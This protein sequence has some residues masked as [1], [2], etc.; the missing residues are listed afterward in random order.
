MVQQSV[1]AKVAKNSVQQRTWACR[2]RTQTHT[3]QTHGADTRRRHTAQTQAL[4]SGRTK[5]FQ[6]H[7]H[8][9]LCVQ[10][11]VSYCEKTRQ[12]ATHTTFRQC[13]TYLHGD[14]GHQGLLCVQS[15]VSYCEKTRQRAT[16]T[17][18][19]Q[20]YTYLRVLQR[21]ADAPEEIR[22]LAGVA[23]EHAH[24]VRQQLHVHEKG[25]Q[26]YVRHP[27]P[28]EVQ[29]V[30]ER[31]QERPRALLVRLDQIPHAFD[32]V[33]PVLELAHD[34]I[35][36][37]GFDGAV[38]R[39]AFE[40]YVPHQVVDHHDRLVQQVRLFHGHLEQEEEEFRN[41]RARRRVLDGQKR[42]QRA[43]LRRE[44]ALRVAQPVAPVEL[45][46]VEVA[47]H[48][49]QPR[50]PDLAVH[51]HPDADAVLHD[52]VRGADDVRVPVE[53]ALRVAP[54]GQGRR[55]RL[56]RGD[57]TAGAAVVD[58]L[59]GGGGG[60]QGARPQL[61]F[62]HV[63][64]LLQLE[65]PELGCRGVRHAGGGALQL[66]A[67]QARVHLVHQVAHGPLVSVRQERAVELGLGE[68]TDF[69]FHDWVFGARTPIDAAGVQPVHQ[70]Q[71]RV[72]HLVLRG[73]EHCAR[74]GVSAR[75]QDTQHRHTQTHTDTHR[76]TQTHTDTHRHTRTGFHD[77]RAAP[78]PLAVGGVPPPRLGVRVR[79][80]GGVV[81][82][83]DAATAGRIRLHGQRRVAA[84]VPAVRLAAQPRRRV[85]ARAGVVQTQH[86][87]AL[88]ARVRPGR[89]RERRLP[90]VPVRAVVLQ[91]PA[92]RHPL[93]RR[94]ILPRPVGARP[95]DRQFKKVAVQNVR[96]R[97]PEANAGAH[98]LRGA[99]HR[100]T[101]DGGEKRR[102]DVAH[103]LGGVAQVPEHVLQLRLR[104]AHGPVAG[105][106]GPHLLVVG[107]HQKR[108]V[109][110]V[111]MA[112][113]GV[114]AQV[115]AGGRR[116][117]LPQL[118]A[119]HE[120]FGEPQGAVVPLEHLPP[121]SLAS[122]KQGHHGELHRQGRRNGQGGGGGAPQGADGAEQT[123]EKPIPVERRFETAVQARR[124]RRQPRGARKPPLQQPVH[125]QRAAVHGL[126]QPDLRHL[127]Y[128]QK[129]EH[130]R[131][132]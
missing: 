127:P 115:P 74:R 117:R 82:K 79:V 67:L 107:G 100:D 69:G 124:R 30:A 66:P 33:P 81:R 111:T 61:R 116:H 57:Q 93:R 17:T 131:R 27:E 4:T 32:D 49:R 128:V 11:G 41:R 23:A 96:Q 98:C 75:R 47:G 85:L 118:A 21:Y 125:G 26:E 2:E 91:R 80:G 94:Q 121:V 22:D 7:P 103:V 68:R 77:L 71:H 55:P 34:Q 102:R 84:A 1:P 122:G 123:L 43:R 113:G 132:I 92:L 60:G 58:V 73:L 59:A 56:C 24:G 101:H 9:L 51:A 72:A 88:Q 78:A 28:D 15:G 65:L 62:D 12:R 63:P 90:Q 14:L 50:V 106:T 105:Q 48:H 31:V 108:G 95:R 8:S 13:Y 130:V 129:R 25:V 126:A 46:G 42:H 3:T 6:N 83:H 109:L 104:A 64:H 39:V 97:Q 99:L 76:H 45:D 40:K 54:F 20:C 35:F 37:E 44:V 114:G 70:R 38:A 119:V 89:V 52:G 86:V 87:V 10:S 5:A 18:F 53:R 16:H 36:H 110:V 19:R 120:R 112:A 29:D